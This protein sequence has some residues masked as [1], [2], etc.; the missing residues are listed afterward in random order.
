VFHMHPMM[1]LPLF[2]LLAILLWRGR[3]RTDTNRAL[4]G[5]GRIAGA[6][7][8]VGMLAFAF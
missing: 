8:L 6:L 5:A 4:A 1:K 7:L 2:I 3:H